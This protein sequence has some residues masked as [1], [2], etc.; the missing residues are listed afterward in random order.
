MGTPSTRPGSGS[1]D[2][3]EPEVIPF[4]IFGTNR[5]DDFPGTGSPALPR[6]KLPGWFR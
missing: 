1:L 5:G 3:A 6:R 2:S 4:P